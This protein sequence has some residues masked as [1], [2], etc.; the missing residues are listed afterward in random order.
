MRNRIKQART[1]LGLTQR[2]LGALI[3]AGHARICAWERGTENPTSMQQQDLAIALGTSMGALFPAG[4]VSATPA[5]KQKMEI[6]TADGLR[7]S[8][9][10]RVGQK[11]RRRMQLYGGAVESWRPCTVVETRS[12]WFRVTLDKSGIC[13][14]F[15]YQA[16]LSDGAIKRAR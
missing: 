15:G 12:G 3:G 9:D 4:D 16:F 6:S 14:C 5:K 13:E 2:Q 11:M 1:A 10:V 7:Q 8:A